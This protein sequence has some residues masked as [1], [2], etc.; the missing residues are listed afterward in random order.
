MSEVD[1]L[2]REPGAKRARRRYADYLEKQGYELDQYIRLAIDWDRKRLKTHDEVTRALELHNKLR[3]RVTAPLEQWI[4]SHQ[5]DRGL[6]ASVHMDAQTFIE[7]GSEVFA[8]ASIQH[9]NI[10]D[11]RACLLRLLNL[12]FSVAELLAASPY[13]RRLVCLDLTWNKIGL[14]GLEA[15]ASSPNLSKVRRLEFNHNLVPSPVDTWRAMEFLD[16]SSTPRLDGRR[17]PSRRST[18]S[19]RGCILTS[20]CRIQIR[21]TSVTRANELLDH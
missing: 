16:S 1:D 18:A 17:L 13:V 19:R 7:Q 11:S 12:Q 3:S 6:V 10:V 5:T 2:F 9:L 4:R 14:R 8:V 20:G 21:F 15:I